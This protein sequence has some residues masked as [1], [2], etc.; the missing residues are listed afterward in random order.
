LQER[1][2][3]PNGVNEKRRPFVILTLSEEI[4][5]GQPIVAAAVTTTL[6]NPLTDEY[7]ELPWN[8]TGAVRTGLKKRC[9]VCCRWVAELGQNDIEETC[10]HVSGGKLKE[11]IQKVMRLHGDNDPSA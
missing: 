7:V 8:P 1:A 3:C 11:I 2:R 10:G 5:R 4:A 6:P 9:A